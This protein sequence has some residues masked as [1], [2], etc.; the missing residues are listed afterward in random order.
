[1][2]EP[3]NGSHPIAN[4]PASNRSNFEWPDKSANILGRCSTRQVSKSHPLTP[5]QS[6]TSKVELNMRLRG[7]VWTSESAIT[8]HTS[9]ANRTS[10]IGAFAQGHNGSIARPCLL[11]LAAL[12]TFAAYPHQ[13]ARSNCFLCLCCCCCFCV[14]CAWGNQWQCGMCTD[15]QYKVCDGDW[16]GGALV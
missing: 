5:L 10:A 14:C 8:S 4:S 2:K 12:C 7:A 11:G 15:A 16:V 13:P 3:T 9:S 1:M 6:H